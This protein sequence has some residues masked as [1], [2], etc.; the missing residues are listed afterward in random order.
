MFEIR[1]SVRRG[2]WMP[3]V[4]GL[5]LLITI[6]CGRASG[7]ERASVSGQVTFDG[8]PVER[9]SIAFIPDGQTVGPTAGAV[10]EKGRYQVP[11]DA[12]PV[13]GTH[14][15]EITAHRAGKQVDVAGVGGAATGPSAAGTVQ[16][17]EMYIPEQYN[18]QSSLK[19]T[20]KSGANVNDFP[21]KSS[22]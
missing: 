15:V 3:R 4:L 8:V 21:L 9:G 10:I 12:G 17:T 22:P 13:L 16:E 11:R 7:P 20:F 2:G 18:K 5:V 1:S 19:A 14:R 6:G